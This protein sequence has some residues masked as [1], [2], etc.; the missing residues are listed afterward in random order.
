MTF[1]KPRLAGKNSR[2][3][4]ILR[5]FDTGA[6]SKF[7]SGLFFLCTSPDTRCSWCRLGVG[8]GVGFT[9]TESL[10]LTE[11]EAFWCRKCSFSIF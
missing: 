2:K 10:D 6:A 5:K 4:T 1:F 9:G 11:F 8:S 7:G 3:I